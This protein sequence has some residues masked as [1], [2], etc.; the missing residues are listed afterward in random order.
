M[1]SVMF[2]IVYSR[3]DIAFAISKLAQFMDEPNASHIRSMKT[4]LRYLRET[5]DLSIQYSPH[6]E[7]NNQVIG[8]SDADYTNNKYNRKSVSGMIFMLNGGPISWR[9]KKQKLILISTTEAEYI[10]LSNIAKHAKWIS[11]FL[12]DI[13][14]PKYIRRK[15]HHGH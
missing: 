7:S 5:I 14:F 10:S 15:N 12:T 3:P 4:L 11:Q 2:P 8:Y 9:S 1:G 6:K 13:G